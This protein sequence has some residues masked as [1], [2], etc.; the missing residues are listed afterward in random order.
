[1]RSF[2]AIN[3]KQVMHEFWCQ[4]SFN[5]SFYSR[6][7]I[8][9][10]SNIKAM[11]HM[12]QVSNKLYLIKIAL[13]SNTVLLLLYIT[14][15]VLRLSVLQFDITISHIKLNLFNLNTADDD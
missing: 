10:C 11:F 14:I 9:N 15:L 3:V 1:M 12:N 5:L 6:K 8:K 13:L 7:G 4:M 2:D